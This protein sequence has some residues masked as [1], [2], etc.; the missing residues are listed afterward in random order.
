MAQKRNQALFFIGVGVSKL[1]YNLTKGKRP[2]SGI[3]KLRKK[4]YRALQ[5]NLTNEKQ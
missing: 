1:I 5:S 3:T 4:C 2:R